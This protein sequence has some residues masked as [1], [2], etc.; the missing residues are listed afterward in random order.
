MA[1]IMNNDSRMVM[2][3]RVVVHSTGAWPNLMSDNHWSI[4]LLLGNDAGSVHMNMIVEDQDDVTGTLKLR[5]LTYGLTTSQIRYWDFETVTDVTVENI[6]KIIK[7]NGRDKY[8][9]SGGGSGCR[10]WV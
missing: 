2:S 4:Y 5:S 3:V 9:F 8:E 10:Y 1:A 7:K 6:V